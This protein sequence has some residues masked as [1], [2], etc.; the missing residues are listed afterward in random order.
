MNPC[1][2]PDARGLPF[3]EYIAQVYRC[4][5]HGFK[6]YEARHGGGRAS[7]GRC[8]LCGAPAGTRHATFCRPSR[9]EPEP[10]PER[11]PEGVFEGMSRAGLSQLADA[12]VGTVMRINGHAVWRWEESS[13]ITRILSD[14][15]PEGTVEL[16][17]EWM[18]RQPD[19]GGPES[20]LRAAMMQW[21]GLRTWWQERVP[22]RW[23]TRLR[24]EPKREP[25]DLVQVYVP[26][27]SEPVH[28][29]ITSYAGEPL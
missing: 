20:A 3:Q 8:P 16:T 23:V 9:P 14:A 5:E 19:L 7:G 13:P 24:W 29:A 28:R 22:E 18:A 10:E 15:R 26:E 12:P 25:E 27:P 17:E 4:P 2:C 11:S 1:T 21:K 6:T